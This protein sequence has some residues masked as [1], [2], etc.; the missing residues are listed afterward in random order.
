MP[1]HKNHY[2]K[3]GEAALFLNVSTQTLR[4]WDRERKLKTH[5]NK[6]N[7]YRLYSISEL[8]NFKENRKR[9]Y[10]KTNK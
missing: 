5:R 1:K 8:Q 6:E 3:I 4:A 2:L 10:N 9:K 7:K